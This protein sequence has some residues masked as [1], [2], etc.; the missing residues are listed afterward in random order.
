MD[1]YIKFPNLGLEFHIDRVA[2]HIGFISIYWYAIAI[3]TGIILGLLISSYIAK[4]DHVNPDI[5][6]DALL[7]GLPSAII[8]ARIYYVVFNFSQ[9]QDNLVD[10]FN[11]RAGGIAIYGAIIG[12]LLSTYIYAKIKK[13]S[14]FQIFDIGSFGLIVGQAVGRWGNFVNQEA[15]GGN[16]NGPFSMS[17]NLIKETLVD[18][19]NSGV[20]INPDI[21]VHPTFLYESVWN[22]IGLF[23]L[24]F[25]H[26]RKKFNGQIFFS[27]LIWY[28]IGRFFIEGLRMDS[29]MLYNFRISQIV[30][31]VSVFIS[32]IVLYYLSK[33]GNKVCGK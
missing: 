17:G 5:I 29:L 2:I 10:V 19:Q 25:I 15:F 4:K 33:K 1:N 18:L 16:T 13:L 3:I 26:K 9:Y 8:C 22:L 12:A 32:G 30:A 31:I 14:I 24:L 21:G 23:V 27:Y 11:I 20:N 7:Y 28:G 6:Y